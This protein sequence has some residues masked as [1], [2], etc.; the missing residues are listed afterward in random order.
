M[1]KLFILAMICIFGC[2]ETNSANVQQQNTE[3]NIVEKNVNEAKVVS[4]KAQ[5]KAQN[6]TFNVGIASPDTGC[7]QYAN[8]WEVLNEEGKLLYRRI[9]A[10]SHVKEQP[11]E[12]WGGPVTVS[13]NEIVII[14]AHMNN[15][16]YGT[17]VFKGSVKDGFKPTQLKANFAFEVKSQQP[18]PSGC[19]F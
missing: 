12:R 2:T 1:K 16:G 11:F 17:T 3:Q 7:E 8:W 6:Y 9:L 19:A 14:R 10:H 5:G 18:Q 4:V 13:N 15:S